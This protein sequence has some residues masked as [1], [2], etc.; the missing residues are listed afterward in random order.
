MAVI[1]QRG[2]NLCTLQLIP[3][4][5]FYQRGLQLRVHSGQHHAMQVQS[6][7]ENVASRANVRAGSPE[8][9]VL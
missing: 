4:F 3:C 1:L 8:L 9:P 6:M 7:A 2:T 5:T